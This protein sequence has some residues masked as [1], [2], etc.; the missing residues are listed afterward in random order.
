MT[1]SF[2]LKGNICHAPTAAGIQARQNALLVCEQG[3]CRGIF[4]ELPDKYRDYPVTDF[5]D[6]IIIPGLCDL[7]L[8]APQYAFRGLWMDLEVVD[9]LNEYTF[10]HESRYGDLDYARPAYQMFVDDLKASPT[11]RACVFATLHTPS[12]LL[13]MELMEQAGLRGFIG[14]VNTD[15]GAPGYLREESAAASLRDTREWLEKSSSFSG[16]L[17]ILTP[18]STFFC[19]GPLMTGLK[20]LQTAYG[21]PLQSHL[22]EN[23]RRLD[24]LRA[25][26]P[27]ARN[28]GDAYDSFGLFGGDCPTVM[29]HCVHGSDEEIELMRERGV[30]VAHCPQSNAN[31]TSGAA[32]AKRL[33]DL[34]VPIGLGTDVAAGARLSILYE[35]AMAIQVSKLRHRL[36][37]ET[38]PALTLAEVFHMATK[39]GGAFF[40][41]VG[42]FEEGYEFDAV[43]L[44]DS[45]VKSPLVLDAVQRL[46][47]LVYLAQDHHVAAKYVAG[48]RL[49]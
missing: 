24:Q 44:D 16:V 6:R 25:L 36:L 48:N 12:T 35:M 14:K 38:S 30:F 45:D 13:L 19:T 31:L 32:P 49:F 34:G 27:G 46:E 37:D 22:S 47:R 8:H 28:D 20:E 17:P 2:V 11:T 33:L 3:V 26:Y 43:V 5:G 42:S 39:G 29:A 9:W 1:N 23:K 7:H 4:D 40:G 41:K 10:P 21:L 15:R 18:R